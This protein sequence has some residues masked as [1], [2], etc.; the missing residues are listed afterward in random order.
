MAPSRP[1]LV[2][3]YSLG[4]WAASAA[5]QSSSDD[6]DP[7]EELRATRD[8]LE[9][10]GR[11]VSCL[12]GIQARL[13]RNERLVQ[14]AIE[15]ERMASAS[16]AARRDA[17]LTVRSL[18]QVRE[19]LRSDVVSCRE[20]SEPRPAAPAAR[21]QAEPLEAD[22]R[23]ST[24]IYIERAERSGGRSSL[25][26]VALQNAL[27]AAAPSFEAC[28]DRA[29][30]QGALP[31]GTLSLQLTIDASGDVRGIVQD[32]TMRPPFGRCLQAATARMRAPGVLASGSATVVYHLRF[33]GP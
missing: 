9:A 6:D 29:T 19:Q 4:L 15:Q 7:E 1:L 22:A 17:R 13:R 2:I 11:E 10:L 27:R 14:E 18:R 12:Q 8:A 3:V 33:P 20:T 28:Y 23:L 26:R 21:T 32:D 16:P 5:A 25:S 30:G 31:R 24:N